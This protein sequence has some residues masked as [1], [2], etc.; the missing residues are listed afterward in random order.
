V[1]KNF[2]ARLKNAAGPLEALTAMTCRGRIASSEGVVGDVFSDAWSRLLV[3]AGF[4]SPAEATSCSSGTSLGG[5]EGFWCVDV[6][7]LGFTVGFL[8]AFAACFPVFPAPRS[9]DMLMRR[10]PVGALFQQERF[11]SL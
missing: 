1:T 3:A 11:Q 4:L 5:V 6:C 2:R 9:V 8:D 7:G 10:V